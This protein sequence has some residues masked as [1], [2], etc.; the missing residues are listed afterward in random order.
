MADF[1]T[2]IRHLKATI[3]GAEKS[4]V[5]AIGGSYGGMLATWFRMKYPHVVV[6]ALAASAPI[7]SFVN[8]FYDCNTYNA[9]VTKDYESIDPECPNVV[10]KSWGIIDKLAAT[11][12]GLDKLS[13]I[14][15]TCKPLTHGGSIKGFMDNAFGSMA[16]VDYPYEADFIGPLLPPWPVKTACSHMTDSSASDE[17]ILMQT[18]KGSAIWFNYTGSA[19]CLDLENGFTN[20][21]SRTYQ[22]GL[23][24][25]GYMGWSF[26]Y[27]SEYIMPFCS[28]G[29][30]DMFEPSTWDVDKTVANCK[31]EWY[32]L[33]SR[34]DYPIKRYGQKGQ[35]SAHSNIIFSN[36]A[37]DPWSGG[38]QL[39]SVSETLIAIVIPEGAHHLDLRSAHPDDPQSVIDARNQEKA[40]M[41]GWINAYNSQ[42]SYRNEEVD[43][44]G[45]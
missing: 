36:G 4:P 26:Q 17:E 12:E 2:L 10:R 20:S 27:C 1:A 30:H 7:Y 34:V 6:G 14:Y 32:G 11:T 15:K 8:D 39:E 16:M 41:R 35:I 37:R 9:I 24:A 22:H 18:A 43:M 25:I 40:I 38:G 5:I 42:N 23:G 29:V 3:P 21:K 44:D 13:H 28:D 45:F 19:D 33:E 31:E